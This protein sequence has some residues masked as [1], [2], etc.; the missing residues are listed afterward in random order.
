[1]HD[2]ASLA[3]HTRLAHCDSTYWH[4]LRRE[5]QRG[6]AR[7][8][9]GK[10]GNENRGKKIEEVSGQRV[11]AR[12]K[13]TTLQWIG[14][15]WDRWGLCWT[16][17]KRRI[18]SRSGYRLYEAAA[19]TPDCSSSGGHINAGVP[20]GGLRRREDARRA[21][22]RTSS[23]PATNGFCLGRLATSATLLPRLQR[24]TGC[25]ACEADHDVQ[26]S[27]VELVQWPTEKPRC[28]DDQDHSEGARSTHISLAVGV[29]D[30]RWESPT[31]CAAR[32]G[33]ASDA[34]TANDLVTGLPGMARQRRV[35]THHAVAEIL[36]LEDQANARIGWTAALVREEGILTG[37]A[38]ELPGD[39]R[40][41]HARNG[42]EISK[43][44]I[45]GRTSTP[46]RFQT[47]LADLR[48]DKLT[49]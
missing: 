42:R 44:E 19:R 46:S 7:Q 21:V 28:P 27:F 43:I 26:I 15:E 16:A 14:S 45:R 10:F 30:L 37:S 20:Q 6:L 25:C 18:A 13:G 34:E 8:R 48:L 40:M 35:L 11:K 2:K 22:A 23:P 31:S 47:G 49:G 36:T 1:M 29:D 17:Q 39:E 33:S 38:A 12:S 3:S 32:T 24:P 5:C 4:G 41:E 9:G